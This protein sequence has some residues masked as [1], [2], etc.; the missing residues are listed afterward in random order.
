MPIWRRWP[1]RSS[2][3]GPSAT[4]RRALPGRGRRV[5][6]GA[7]GF[8]RAIGGQRVKHPARRPRPAAHDLAEGDRRI[9]FGHGVFEPHPCQHLLGA[10]ELLHGEGAAFAVE[11]PALERRHLL[12]PRREGFRRPVRDVGWRHGAGGGL[13]RCR[14]TRRCRR[15]W[16]RRCCRRLG[17]DVPLPACFDEQ[18]GHDGSG[19]RL[20]SAF[21]LVFLAVY[22]HPGEEGRNDHRGEL[23]GVPGDEGQR[24]SGGDLLGG[25]VL[26]DAITG[27]RL[28]EELAQRYHLRRD[29]RGGGHGETFLKA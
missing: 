21:R 8:R 16:V 2:T 7:G 10:Q 9:H 17:E 24:R 1:R 23:F 20:L 19:D 6:G 27:A 12:C 22:G 18:V 13:S 15:R 26:L 11:Q 25:E 3:I 14:C 29:C 4:T 28:I 5:P